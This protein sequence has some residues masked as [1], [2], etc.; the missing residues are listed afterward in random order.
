MTFK[1]SLLLTSLLLLVLACGNS[2]E[3]A[4]T[5]FLNAMKEGDVQQLCEYGHG[6]EEEI[7]D[8]SVSEVEE[9][10]PANPDMSWKI[11]TTEFSFNG[12]SATVE[13]EVSYSNTTTI[14]IIY[15]CAFLED[16]WVVYDARPITS[17][18]EATSTN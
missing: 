14:T 3:T 9:R 12:E 4:V 11:L 16:K 7:G 13:V 15:T 5:G 1:K 8:L 6:V 10:F 18:E 2:P 17:Y